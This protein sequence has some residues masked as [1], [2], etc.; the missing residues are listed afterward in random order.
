MNATKDVYSVRRQEGRDGAGH[1]VQGESLS[2]RTLGRVLLGEVLGEGSMGVVYKGQHM[3]LGIPVAVKVM[4][5]NVNAD[6]ASTYRERFQEEARIAARLDHPGI[7]RV[8]DFGQS[9]GLAYLV[10]EYI[11]GFT[12]ESFLRRRG[13][14]GIPEQSCLRLLLS[15]AVALSSA[16]KAGI[17]HR[18]LKP[19]NLL[20]TKRGN[21][22][23]ADLG[24]AKVDDAPG[25]T[26]DNVVLGSPAYMA[27]ESANPRMRVDHR[28][29][30]YSL[31]VVA[32]EMTFGV[33][34]YRGSVQEILHGHIG[35]QARFD[36][37]HRFSDT[38][39][40]LIRDMMAVHPERR[41]AD[42]AML[43][44]RLR[45]ALNQAQ[46]RGQE[47]TRHAPAVTKRMAR[48]GRSSLDSSQASTHGDGI[49]RT[50][51]T[52]GEF[53]NMVRFFDR[54]SSTH[55][56]QVIVHSYG[57]ERVLVAIALLAVVS[58][59]VWALLAGVVVEGEFFGS[60]SPDPAP[61]QGEEGAAGGS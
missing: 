60:E 8:L 35:G 22:K 55:N 33:L 30:I 13:T 19:S 42:C 53:A 56:D 3:T 29:D 34:P 31:G 58:I 36:L 18:D 57:R 48:R 32:Y 54:T 40:S 25:M 28:S 9:R 21:L 52:M 44:K 27:P 50:T 39:V 2:G 49:H 37:S 59:A 7:V 10:M 17:I 5:L 4:K 24:L 12:L 41:P 11:E 61:E 20:L 1:A 38:T 14:Q 45:A 43:A 46:V 15:A 47:T 23:I 16:H 26:K 6:G 51:S